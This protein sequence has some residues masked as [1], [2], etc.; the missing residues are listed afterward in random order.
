MFSIHVSD[1]PEMTWVPSAPAVSR[2]VGWG[3]AR[4]EGTQ[5]GPTHI[6]GAREAVVYAPIILQHAGGG[7]AHAETARLREQNPERPLEVPS[8]AYRLL[9]PIGQRQSHHQPKFLS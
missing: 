3:Q 9:H 5:E 4:L 8:Q 6:S 1:F 7:I 2:R